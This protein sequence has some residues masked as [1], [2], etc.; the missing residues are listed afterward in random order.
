MFS[1][2]NVSHYISSQ[3]FFIKITENNFLL[4]YALEWMQ[5]V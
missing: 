1:R 2:E 4:I 5:F 3:L